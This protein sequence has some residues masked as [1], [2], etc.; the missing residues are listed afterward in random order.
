M[1]QYQHKRSQSKKETIDQ[2]S[3]PGCYVTR[4]N[5]FGKISRNK[6]LQSINRVHFTSSRHLVSE[7]YLKRIK[8]AVLSGMCFTNPTIRKQSW[9][10][11][12]RSGKTIEHILLHVLTHDHRY[13][14]RWPNAERKATTNNRTTTSWRDS[15]KK[16]PS[17]AW[18]HRSNSWYRRETFICKE[19]EYSNT[20][21]SKTFTGYRWAEKM[22]K[23]G[24]RWPDTVRNQELQERNTQS[25]H[26]TKENQRTYIDKINVSRFNNSSN[27]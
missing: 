15:K 27:D 8:V 5:F 14:S 16:F 3:Y 20:H 17:L 10:Y 2:F 9:V 25:R 13:Q 22:V 18:T 11:N 6:N 24:M 1:T 4:D 21:S 26:L 12:Y 19:K 23:Q 7:I